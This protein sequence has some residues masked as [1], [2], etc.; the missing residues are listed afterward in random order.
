[1][2]RPY[3]NCNERLEIFLT[4]FCNI[5]C[6]VDRN[7]FISLFHK[8]KYQWGSTK[9]YRTGLRFHETYF[10]GMKNKKP[11]WA[12]IPENENGRFWL[13]RDK[14]VIYEAVLNIILQATAFSRV[15][16]S[17]HRFKKWGNWLPQNWVFLNH[18]SVHT[19]WRSTRKKKSINP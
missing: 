2:L 7:F 8:F 12:A 14:L 9:Y 13:F 17:T 18:S 4:C 10:Y 16:F 3:F 15:F 6:Y 5:L 11:L 19:L 1:M